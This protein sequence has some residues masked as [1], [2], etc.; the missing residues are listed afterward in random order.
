MTINLTELRD[1]PLGK[2]PSQAQLF[3]ALL[4]VLPDDRARRCAPTDESCFTFDVDG[5]SDEALDPR[6]HR[7]HFVLSVSDGAAT[8][9]TT[10]HDRRSRKWQR[11]E[12][13]FDAQIMARCGAGSQNQ[14]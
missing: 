3:V 1:E 12:I 11:F 5:L 2:H 10:V 8:D 13:P 6:A 14:F 9:A 7:A 4:S